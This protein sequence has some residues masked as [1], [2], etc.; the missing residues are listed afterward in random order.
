MGQYQVSCSLLLHIATDVGCSVSAG[1]DM[2]P[3]HLRPSSSSWLKDGSYAQ[4]MPEQQQQQRDFLQRPAA[5]KAPPGGLPMR[6]LEVLPAMKRSASA[7]SLV[8]VPHDDVR[9]PP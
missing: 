5:S 7:D 9:S 6:Q 2:G 1:L 3:Q 8:P 4:A